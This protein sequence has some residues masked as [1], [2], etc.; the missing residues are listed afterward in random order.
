[1]AVASWTDAKLDRLLQLAET[2]L[3]AQ[4]T[5]REEIVANR[6]EI[7]ANRQAIAEQR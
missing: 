3:R 2:N 5:S 6:A 4:Q 1:M 7:A